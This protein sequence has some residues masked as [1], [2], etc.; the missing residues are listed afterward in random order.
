M[1]HHSTEPQKRNR[2]GLATAALVL[3]VALA[4]MWAAAVPASAGINA[5]D[6]PREIG[7]GFTASVTAITGNT[8]SVD[9][10]GVAFDLAVTGDTAIHAPPDRN[11]GIEALSADPPSRIAVLAEKAITGPDGTGPNGSVAAKIITVIPAKATRKHQRVIATDKTNGGLKSLDEDGE[12]RELTGGPSA[13]VAKGEGLVL[14]IQKGNR[15]GAIEKIKAFL[16]ANDIDARLEH[17]SEAGDADPL[18][19]ARL[20]EI[21]SKR[22]AA[23]EKRLDKTANN[24]KAEIREFV[25]T[26]VKELRDRRAAG[27]RGAGIGRDVSECARNLLG[28]RAGRFADLTQEQQK[29]LLEKCLGETRAELSE[30]PKVAI[31]SPEAGQPV[32]G[33]SAFVISAEAKDDTGIASVTFIVNGLRQVEL[34]APPYSMEITVPADAVSLGVE[35]VAIDLDGNRATDAVKVRVLDGNP[36]PRVKITSPKGQSTTAGRSDQDSED[37]RSDDDD[38]EDDTREVRSERG[39]VIIEGETITISAEASD[40]GSVASVGFTVNGQ[41]LATLTA[42]PYTLQY[43]VPATPSAAAPLPLTIVA[44]ATDDTGQTARDT[45]LIDTGRPENNAP[46]VRITEPSTDAKLLQ[47]DTVVFKAETDD[48]GAVVLVTFS[49]DGETLASVNTSPFTHT[50]IVPGGQDTGGGKSSSYPPNVFVGKA[51]LDGETAP[52]GTVVVAYVPGI[53]VSTTVIKATAANEAGLTGSASLSLPVSS[54]RI[55]AGEGVVTAG[56]YKVNAEQPPGYSFSGEKVEFTLGGKEVRQTG[57]WVQGGAD[58]LDLIAD[59]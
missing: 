21:K 8:V 37:N 15:P 6:A 12:E 9:A 30:G 53:F 29:Q 45:V 26:K 1:N 43:T 34:T 51:T 46:S 36:P 48:D 42:P 39:I 10:K 50:Y 35:A 22:D 49:V 7:R 28:R 4:A 19:K 11:V 18:R 57:T 14:I 20:E 25:Q 16:K 5:Q 33:G 56:E 52:D 38:S 24:A 3:A 44:V 59:G 23:K 55:K 58:V 54:P 40:N 41:A 31:G 32:Q 2:F 47:G 17:L 27:G 13:D